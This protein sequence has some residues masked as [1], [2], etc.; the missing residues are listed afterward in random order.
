M[1]LVLFSRFQCTI[2]SSVTFL[3]ITNFFSLGDEGQ[4]LRYIQLPFPDAILMLAP[5]MKV[6][7]SGDNHLKS[8]EGRALIMHS[9]SSL[10]LGPPITYE[11]QW[12]S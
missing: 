11:A 9:L 1:L 3:I 7:G 8:R 5:A 2:D 10:S 12:T 4:G 6:A